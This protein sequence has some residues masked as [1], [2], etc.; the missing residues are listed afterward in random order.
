M[1]TRSISTDRLRAQAI[2]ARAASTTPT[3]FSCISGKDTTHA[4]M[5]RTILAPA[6]S[7]HPRLQRALDELARGDEVQ[8]R[9]SRTSSG[10]SSPL[11]SRSMGAC[12]LAAD[13]GGSL[14]P[15]DSSTTLPNQA[16]VLSPARRSDTSVPSPTRRSDS[17]VSPPTRRSDASATTSPMR[18]RAVRRTLTPE[19]WPAQR[20]F[21]F[22][23]VTSGAEHRGFSSPALRR[24][25]TNG[26]QVFGAPANIAVVNATPQRS[27]VRPGGPPLTMSRQPERP[28]ATRPLQQRPLPQPIATVE[29][30]VAPEEESRDKNDQGAEQPTQM[31]QPPQAKAPLESSDV[32]RRSGSPARPS[33]ACR[34][35]KVYKRQRPG[36]SVL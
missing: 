34:R 7:A 4:R 33:W 21:A 15:R 2:R 26:L 24:G 23:A 31:P 36:E 12:H 30:S 5:L 6:A 13:F 22:G 27:R 25:G 1:E 3:P 10:K 16:S 9:L 35:N 19:K 18:G 20:S 17:S 14:S 11:L 8:H 32:R 29:P 28:A